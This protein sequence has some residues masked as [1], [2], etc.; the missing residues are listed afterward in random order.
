M[1]SQKS[2]VNILLYYRNKIEQILLR[3]VLKA[4]IITIRDQKQATTAL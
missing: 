4:T 3:L 1:Y 2:I